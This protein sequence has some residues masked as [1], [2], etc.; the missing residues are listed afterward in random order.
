MVQKHKFLPETPE[1]DL[2]SP[3]SL[4]KWYIDIG[5]VGLVFIQ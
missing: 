1:L 2:K 5:V 4:M 3:A